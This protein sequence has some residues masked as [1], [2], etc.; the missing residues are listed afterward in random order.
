MHKAIFIDQDSSNLKMCLN[1]YSSVEISNLYFLLFLKWF[2]TFKH[3]SY[4]KG[5]LHR[6]WVSKEENQR[7]PLILTSL[8]FIKRL[9]VKLIILTPKDNC[10]SF[11]NH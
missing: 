3:M 2:I 6:G 1:N 7:S 10:T 8:T 11:K 4:L 9:K 5:N